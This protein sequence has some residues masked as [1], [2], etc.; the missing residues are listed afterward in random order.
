MTPEEIKQHFGEDA[1]N[2]LYDVLLDRPVHALADWIL[3]YQSE[4]EI[5]QW[6]MQLRQDEIETEGETK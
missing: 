3:S 2:K 6:V 5:A 1:L 4:K